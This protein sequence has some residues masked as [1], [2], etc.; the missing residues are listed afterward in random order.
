MANTRY[1]RLCWTTWFRK[2]TTGRLGKG[3]GEFW[4]MWWMSGDWDGGC[5]QVFPG[6]MML[7]RGEK[8][9]F[10]SKIRGNFVSP[11]CG[12]WTTSWPVNWTMICDWLVIDAE[13]SL[14]VPNW[15]VSCDWSELDGW[16]LLDCS[17]LSRV[18]WLV[19]TWWLNSSWLFQTEPCLVIGQEL[20]VK[21]EWNWVS[22]TVAC[23]W[24]ELDDWNWVCWNMIPDWSEPDEWIPQVGQLESEY[25]KLAGWRRWN[26]LWDN[27]SALEILQVSK[28]LLVYC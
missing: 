3:C 8:P 22:W 23:D 25:H 17:K 27:M 21:S 7:E 15:A 18:L 4:R 24:S 28:G 6:R 19:R 9:S 14:I 26:K 16:V 12:I 10:Y 1:E 20:I 13:F 2:H 5:R 11:K